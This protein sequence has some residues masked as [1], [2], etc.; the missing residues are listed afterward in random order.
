[1]KGLRSDRSPPSRSRVGLSPVPRK[2]SG[3]IN[4]PQVIIG[5]PPRARLLQL[6]V[7]EPGGLGADAFAGDGD[8]EQV[9]AVV[10]GDALEA[11]A[12]RG[13]QLFHG[14]DRFTVHALRAGEP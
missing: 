10:A 12:E 3:D 11:A 1:M 7:L 13:L 14:G 2:R 8:V 4:R 9:R 5:T 6:P